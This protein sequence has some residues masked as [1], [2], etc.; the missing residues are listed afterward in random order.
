MLVPLLIVHALIQIPLANMPMTGFTIAFVHSIFNVITTLILFPAS[1]LLERI[2]YR[3]ISGEE[4]TKDAI[5]L[6][7]N[8][9]NTPSVAISECANLAVNMAYISFDAVISALKLVKNFSTAGVE[10]VN[11]SEDQLDIYEDKLGTYLVQLSGRNLSEA[12]SRKASELLRDIGDFERIGDHAVNVME[13]AQEMRDKNVSF[14]PD[15]QLEITTIGA[16]V[17]EVLAMTVN[18]FATNDVSL[19]MRV[20]PLEQVVDELVFDI[21]KNHIHRLQA[22][23]C[24]IELGFILS[25]LL[26]DLERISDH[27]SNIASSVVE[28]VR[29]NFALH[30]YAANLKLSGGGA[31]ESEFAVFKEKYRLVK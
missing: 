7:E 10:A 9:F 29:G 21:R 4:K 27:C 6:D 2:A 17:E 14:S 30:D 18:A 1:K 24:T 3:V 16:A 20:E 13:S 28:A 12:D 23:I 26:T 15:G 5:Y 31:F 25:D 8:L 22:G 19:A 11:E